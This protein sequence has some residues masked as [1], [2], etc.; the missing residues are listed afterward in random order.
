MV[1]AED[2]GKAPQGEDL[3]VNLGIWFRAVN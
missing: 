1:A 2:S 3:C